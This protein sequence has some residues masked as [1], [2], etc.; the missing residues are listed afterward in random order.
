MITSVRPEIWQAVR[1]A[2]SSWSRRIKAPSAGRGSA[3]RRPFVRHASSGAQRSPRFAPKPQT[4]VR[5]E[6]QRSI[7]HNEPST[8]PMYMSGGCSG[9]LSTTW[10]P[11]VSVR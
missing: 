9:A 8:E 10:W 1:M 4:Y 7:P 3:L 6:L 2:C 5:R 11:S